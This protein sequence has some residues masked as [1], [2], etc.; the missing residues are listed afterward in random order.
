M[1]QGI[2]RILALC[3]AS[4]ALVSNFAHSAGL[5]EIP[6]DVA[7]RLYSKEL[8]DPAQPIGPSAYRDWKP[9]KR[10]SMDYRIR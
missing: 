2:K 7:Q 3:V 6:P 5:D 1:K 10:T 8:L 9:K 4:V